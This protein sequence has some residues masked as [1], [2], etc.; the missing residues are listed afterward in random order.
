MSKFNF[1]VF[2]FTEAT[3]LISTTA[4]S[5]CPGDI[6]TFECTVEGGIATVWKGTVFNLCED[7]DI[8]F[9]H[10]RLNDINETQKLIDCNNV[11]TV[12]A[13][14]IRSHNLTY[15]SEFSFTANCGLD[16]LT[17]ECYKDDESNETLIGRK[18]VKGINILIY[19]LI[20][21]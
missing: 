14:I 20:P 10:S 7:Q 18:T 9:R 12:V 13:M 3:G 17:V 4:S 19:E 6:L 2:T 11:T 1:A 8:S 15:T 16:G 21:Q 5:N